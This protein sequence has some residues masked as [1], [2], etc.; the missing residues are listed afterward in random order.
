MRVFEKGTLHVDIPKKPKKMTGTRLA[1]VLNLDKWNTPFKTWCAITKTY[2]DPF[3]ENKY[4]LAGKV[5]EPKIINYLNK[6]YFLN[7]VK[8]PKDVFPP[9]FF[10]C[11]PNTVIPKH[12]GDFFHDEPIFGGMWDALVYE[13][14]KPVAVIEIKT[15]KRV[16]DWEDGKAPI[17]YSLQ[18]ALYAK[19]LGLDQV[20]MVAA[21]LEETD[22]D[23]PENFKPKADNT[24]VDDFLVS[25]RF[26]DLD[27]KLRIAEEWWNRHILTGVSPKFDEKKDAELLKLL[28]TNTLSLD[29]TDTVDLFV[30]AEMLAEEISR[31]EEAELAEKKKRLDEIKALIKKYA[32]E[33]LR[34]DDNKV[35]IKTQKA[36]WT[37]TRV[38]TPQ[39]DKA[40]MERDGILD[41]YLS[42][43]TTCKLE[44]KL[45]GITNEG[46]GN[47]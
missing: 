17:Y 13:D 36:R 43:K 9:E 24:I 23:H 42:Y 11:Y 40:A 8:S 30:E 29:G 12:Q 46:N 41:K 28:R 47:M 22:Y 33:Q 45:G 25:E 15:S 1:S 37:L 7:G 27:D 14:G 35:E 38:T 6:F 44:V 10:E 39:I 19:L 3:S 4:T 26:P 16:E 34:E 5:I 18:A 21:F 20:Y 31:I 2:E 32:T